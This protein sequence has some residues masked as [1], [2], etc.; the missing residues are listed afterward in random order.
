MTVTLVGCVMPAPVSP[1]A[2]AEP[3]SLVIVDGKVDPEVLSQVK[4]IRSEGLSNAF[5]LSGAILRR[6]DDKPLHY[7][8]YYDY[9]SAFTGVPTWTWQVCGSSPKCRL[10]VCKW[11][12]NGFDDHRLRVVVSNAAMN[13]AAESL[14]DFPE[15]TAYDSIEWQLKL[16][17]ECPDAAGATP[18]GN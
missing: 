4:I 13:D 16:D 5:D 12:G 9:D 6:N 3:A 10:Q 1:P 15:G 2:I 7:F 18:G 14:W 11:S 8:W 17:G